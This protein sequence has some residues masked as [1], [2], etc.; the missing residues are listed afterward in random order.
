LFSGLN[1]LKDISLDPRFATLCGYTDADIDT[2]FAPELDGLDRDAIRTWYNGYSW[3]GTERVYNPFDVL[4]LFDERAFKPHWFRTGSPRFLFETLMEKAVHPR[5]LEGC[6]RDET[7]VSKFDVEDISA[8]ALLFQT[9]YLTIVDEKR[10]GFDTFYKLDYP[11]REVQIS[12]NRELLAYLRPTHRMPEEEGK[13]LRDLLEVHD[14]DGFAETLRAYLASLPYQWSTSG[15]LARYE[16]W[17]AGLLHMAFRAIGVDV[18]SE[19]ASSRGRA[20]LVVLTGGQVF[21]FEFKM[22]ETADGT[23]AA[24]DAALAQIRNRGYAEKYRD[25][26]EPVHLVAIACGRD[27]RNLL[28]IRVKPTVLP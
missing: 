27:T 23:E 28:D 8:E 13:T 6:W 3:R 2:V 15:D 1:N 24:L 4:L 26:K 22:V 25:R 21:L 16:A 5:E 9:G 17:Y 19:D 10:E 14:F 20:D 11:N 18:R 12:L 7:L